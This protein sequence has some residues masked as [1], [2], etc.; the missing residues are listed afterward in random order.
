MCFTYVLLGAF[1]IVFSAF[2]YFL[3]GLFTWPYQEDRMNVTEIGEHDQKIDNDEGF[4]LNMTEN[5][6]HITP[7]MN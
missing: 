7:T 5:I 4:L 3:G 1:F 2:L 6:T